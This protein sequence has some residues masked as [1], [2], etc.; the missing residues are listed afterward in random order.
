MSM[1]NPPP[2]HLHPSGRNNILGTRTIYHG[3]GESPFNQVC[4]AS[5]EHAKFIVAAC[6][7]HGPLVEACREAADYLE[8]LADHGESPAAGYLHRK[9]LGAIPTAAGAAKC[10]GCD[11]AGGWY[12]P[13]NDQWVACNCSTPPAAIPK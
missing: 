6:N 8:R 12:S 4:A 7:S 10:R 3:A 9:L 2:W 5:P 1:A 13:D 11:G